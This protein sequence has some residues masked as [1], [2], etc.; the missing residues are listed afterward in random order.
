MPAAHKGST[1]AQANPHAILAFAAKPDSRN[2]R[3]LAG[4]RDHRQ[5]A[6]TQVRGRSR[7]RRRHSVAGTVPPARTERVVR[8]TT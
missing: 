5:V 1:A 4:P 3:L 7:N 8:V 6:Q 2:A